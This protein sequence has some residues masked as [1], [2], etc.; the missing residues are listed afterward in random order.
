MNFGI[1]VELDSGVEG[2]VKSET[3]SSRKRLTHD[4]KNYTLSDGKTTFRLGQKVK[5]KVVGVNLGDRRAEFM[6]VDKLCCENKKI[7][8]KRRK[9]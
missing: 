4:E 7:V 1:F 9:K 3:I 8:A 2:L 6:L 5:I